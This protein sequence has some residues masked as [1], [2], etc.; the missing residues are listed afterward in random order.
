LAAAKAA[1]KAAAEAAAEAAAAAE[2]EAASREA[3]RLM[4]VANDVEEE[5]QSGSP[6]SVLA[7][8][9]HLAGGGVNGMDMLAKEALLGG[10]GVGMSAVEA[11]IRM[12]RA[13][14]M[15]MAVARLKFLVVR[16]ACCR[17]QG[18][19]RVHLAKRMAKKWIQANTEMK[20]AM[21]LKAICIPDD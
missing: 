21:R 15:V 17:L 10:S 19:Y 20:E 6:D 8:A 1:A 2:V 3:S 16:R 14:R 11:A 18:I 7:A 13:Y 12:Q 4:V 9:G 5:E